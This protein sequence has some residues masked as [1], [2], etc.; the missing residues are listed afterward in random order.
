MGPDFADFRR[1]ADHLC[2]YDL[3]VTARFHT[4]VL[5]AQLG[6]PWIGIEG[7]SHR[8]R[9]G[10]RGIVDESQLI[11]T[12]GEPDWPEHVLEVSGSATASPPDAVDERRAQ[13]RA[14]YEAR[15]PLSPR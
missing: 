1:Y 3:V 4:A 10:L 15:F 5:C 14:T 8:I 6:V 11:G 9:E 12:S 2:G 7:S 13:I